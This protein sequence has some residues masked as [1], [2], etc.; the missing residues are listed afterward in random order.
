MAG[1][2]LT[3]TAPSVLVAVRRSSSAAFSSGRSARVHAYS[4]AALGYT[5]V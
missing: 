5:G 4:D 1:T 3:F 2:V